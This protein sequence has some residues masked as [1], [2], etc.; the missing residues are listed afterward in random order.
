MAARMSAAW[1]TFV[2]GIRAVSASN[3]V[4]MSTEKHVPAATWCRGLGDSPTTRYRA[5]W[6]ATKRSPIRAPAIAPALVKKSWKVAGTMPAIVLAV[7]AVN[8]CVA[9]SA[10]NGS[11]SGISPR[12][13]SYQDVCARLAPSRLAS[14]TGD[15]WS[16]GRA[17]SALPP[18]VDIP[19]DPV[20]MC[21]VSSAVAPDRRLGR[22]AVLTVIAFKMRSQDE[23]DQYVSIMVSARPH[24]SASPTPQSIP[25]LGDQ[26]IWAQETGMLGVVKGSRG[27]TISL[28]S[29]HLGPEGGPHVRQACIEIARLVISV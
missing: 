1:P 27:Y 16:A 26:A 9:C 18:G 8:L 4:L 3:K 7:A 14:I 25:G 28:W 24:G 6:M 23:A 10:V 22:G 13:H 29:G 5:I 17:T 20:T 12:A 19:G 15:S 21:S 2:S 11:N